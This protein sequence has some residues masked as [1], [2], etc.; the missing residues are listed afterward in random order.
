MR[1]GTIG[2]FHRVGKAIAIDIIVVMIFGAVLVQIFYNIVD[3]DGKVLII[4][5]IVVVPN[6]YGDGVV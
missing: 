2:D 3:G 5:H 6:P 4:R 1:I